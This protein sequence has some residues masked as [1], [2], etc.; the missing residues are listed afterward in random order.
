VVV[1]E[2]GA[3]AMRP[4]LRA[5]PELRVLDVRCRCASRC[6]RAASLLA[7]NAGALLKLQYK[8]VYITVLLY[9]RDINWAQKC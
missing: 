9:L 2:R 5:L 1:T 3:A 8:L 6:G 4:A 7:T